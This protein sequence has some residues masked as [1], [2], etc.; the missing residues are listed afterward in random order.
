MGKFTVKEISLNISDIIKKENS[1]RNISVEGEISEF[2][3]RGKTAYFLLKEGDYILSCVF[4]NFTYE[5]I[6]FDIEL[7]MKVV[8]SGNISTYYKGRSIYQLICYKIDESGEGKSKREFERLKNK[9]SCEGL[10]SNNKK[11]KIPKFS[12]IIGLV[13]A[14]GSHAYGD[15]I[16]KGRELYPGVQF[17]FSPCKVQGNGAPL[18]IIKALQKLEKTKVDVIILARGG[19]SYED[20]QCY[21]DEK[22]AR[23]IA[24]MTKPIITG[25][26]HEYD[27]TIADLVADLRCTTPTDAADKAIMCKE[28][29]KKELN[30]LYKK[31]IGDYKAILNKLELEK[32][33]LNSIIESKDINYIIDDNKS[34][35]DSELNSIF[36][37]LEIKVKNMQNSI[38]DLQKYIVDIA[39]NIIDGKSE[40]L[41]NLTQVHLQEN[42]I[43][44]LKSLEIQKNKCMSNIKLNMNKTI[45]Y[46]NKNLEIIKDINKLLINK[47]NIS[48]NNLQNINLDI[49]RGI[50]GLSKS[51]YNNKLENRDIFYNICKSIKNILKE[52]SIEVKDI[53]IDIDTLGPSETLNRGYSIISKMDGSIISGLNDLIDNGVYEIKFSDGEIIASIKI[54]N[55]GVVVT[56]E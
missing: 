23:Y 7:G 9:L 44:S 38:N 39:V 34:S 55:K 10:L 1:L 24:Q 14:D 33:H 32:E 41:I 4:F 47:I 11:K 29:Q 43:N 49:E 48:I 21:N 31:V 37:T 36:N 8:C 53:I 12:K 18:S 6:D 56:N 46:E 19:G 15:I 51:I 13:T 42:F 30:N 28:Y 26:G 50:I 40:F 5:K 27:T 25:I 45:Y 16:K 17:I 20:L 3:I 54:I 35:I 2:C 22:L 52:K